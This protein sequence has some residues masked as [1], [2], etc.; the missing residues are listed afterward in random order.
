MHFNL[1]RGFSIYLALSILPGCVCSH[2]SRIAFLNT[3]VQPNLPILTTLAVILPFVVIALFIVLFSN[4][5]LK[6][7]ANPGVQPE[8]TIGIISLVIAL[9]FL[10]MFVNSTI[11]VSSILSGNS[12][13]PAIGLGWETPFGTQ[14]V[15]GWISGFLF[16]VFVLLFGFS[17]NSTI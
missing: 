11:E 3:R 10:L 16:G 5:N 12:E 15:A 17:R 7:P 1:K 13:L 14:F 4:V 9:I 6:A 2:F 8:K